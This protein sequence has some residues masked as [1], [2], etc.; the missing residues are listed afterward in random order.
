MCAC[1][2]SFLTLREIQVQRPSS[3]HPVCWPP[4]P[5]RGCN[6]KATPN[7]VDPNPGNIPAAR[8]YVSAS[9]RS[10]ILLWGHSSRMACH[11]GSHCLWWHVRGRMYGLCQGHGVSPA[12]SQTASAL[13]GTLSALFTHYPGFRDGITHFGR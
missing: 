2:D 10:Q 3:I 4:S 1:P 12:P 7:T 9:V 11:P 13:T 8:H 5:G 6:P